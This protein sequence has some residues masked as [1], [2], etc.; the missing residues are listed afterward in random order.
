M[1]NTKS[2]IFLKPLLIACLL[3]MTALLPI[4]VYGSSAAQDL[5]AQ[6]AAETVLLRSDEEGL[7]FELLVPR[8]EIDE[9]GRVRVSGLELS[10]AEA[11]APNLPYFSTYIAVPPGASYEVHVVDSDSSTLPAAFIEPVASYTLEHT[12]TKNREAA[13]SFLPEVDSGYFSTS[14]P[15][16]VPDPAIY[17]SD[18]LYPEQSYALSE[19]IAAGD[20]RLLKLDLYPMR[21]NAGQ[22][23]LQQAQRLSVTVAFEG[24]QLP[25]ADGGERSASSD[26]YWRERVLNFPPASWRVLASSQAAAAAVPLP[27]GKNTCKI[28]VEED[29]IQAIKGSELG[30]LGVN[31]K[32]LNPDNLQMMHR[33]QSVA[34]QFVNVDGGADFGTADEIRFYG[35]QFD[36]SRYEDMYVNHNVFWLWVGSGGQ[37]IGT[38]NNEAGKGY[39]KTTTFQ[40]SLTF[41]PHNSHFG[42]LAIDWDKSPNEP[43]PWH[44]ELLDARFSSTDSAD[45]PVALPHP[46]RT[47][48]G[49]AD[50]TV[51]LTSYYYPARDASN[52]EFSA[53]VAVNG[54]GSPSTKSWA[55]GENL[56]V[57][58]RVDGSALLVADA[59]GISKN[60]VN[61]KV[62]IDNNNQVGW[63]FVTRIT[64]DYL[65]NLR[66]I[67]DQ[68]IF[69]SD[70]AGNREFQIEGFSTEGAKKVLVWDVS[71]RYAPLS[72]A[73]AGAQTALDSTNAAVIV[74]RPSLTT[75][76]RFIATTPDNIHQLQ[77]ASISRYIPANLTPPQKEAQWLA[78][79]HESLLS[80]AQDLAGYRTSKSGLSSWVVDIED[81]ANQ[82]GY[83]FNTPEAVRAYLR[84]AFATWNEPPRY[85]AIFGD[86]TVNPRNLPCAEG[87]NAN[88]NP[89]VDKPTL[90]PTDMLFVDHYRG[91]IPVDYTF[92]LLNGDD[93]YPELAVG[94]IPSETL[95]EAQGVVNKIKRYEANLTSGQPW[96]SNALFVADNTDGGGNFCIESEKTATHLLPSINKEFLCLPNE[97]AGG[98]TLEE[99]TADLRAELTRQIND[100]GMSVLNYRGHGGVQLWAGPAILSNKDQDIWLNTGRP[101]VILSADCLDGDF[102]TVWTEALSETFINLD[103]NRGSA[104]HWSSTGLGFSFQHSVLLNGLYDGLFE[105]KLA[106]LGDAANYSKANYLSLGYDSSEAYAFTLQGDPAMIFYPSSVNLPMV[107]AK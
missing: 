55:N 79:S 16:F 4:V 34:Y 7:S 95:A 38:V 14:A 39:A 30:C 21:Y 35:W 101:L 65:R 106:T 11:G 29:G 32:D 76:S 50:F 98:P 8:A 42:G 1:K 69:G 36:G 70:K 85:L 72:I 63:V 24:A 25:E 56:N 104:A 75:N 22:G 47:G 45:L 57:Q 13:A 86:A 77:G 107:T 33:G 84:S 105:Y 9:K 91:L 83:G 51:E 64:A 78:V 90:V 80:A 44:W 20:L 2:L 53:E 99:L 87:C 93:L 66:A 88:W 5:G 37:K 94:R 31:L 67:N 96:V 46:V 10:M 61:V 48:G 97:E 28:E 15:S 19:E 59:V 81:V 43:T 89:N 60:E 68:V 74:G 12:L 71:D 40:E 92:S 100:V 73:V 26:R 103:N 52:R 27:V 62:D 23:L 49:T 54:G 17:E 102:A 3:S 58:H 18:T 82:Y 6:S 41:W